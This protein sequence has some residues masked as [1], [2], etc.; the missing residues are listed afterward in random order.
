MW[1]IKWA[2]AIP[3][4]IVIA[5]L[6]FALVVTT[7]AAGLTVLVTG[8][9]PRA[10][11]MFSVGVLRWNWRVGFYAYSALGTDRYPPFSL[12]P[13]DYPAE[14]DVVYPERLSRGLVLVKWWLLVIPH[15]FIVGILTGGGAALNSASEN[16]GAGW[17]ISLVGLLVLIAAIGLLFTGRYLPGLFDLIVGL[18]RW[19]YRVGSYVLLLRDEYPPFRLDQGSEEPV[20]PGTGGPGD[21]GSAMGP[22]RRPGSTPVAE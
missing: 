13:A 8:R 5:L 10:W 11:F 21:A 17:S 7:I 9:Y 20:S 2:L 14:L 15:L 3:H 18:N 6:W 4:Y 12:A 16:G 22:D 1:L 19:V